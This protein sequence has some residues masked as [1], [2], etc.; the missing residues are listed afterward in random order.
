MLSVLL[1][2]DSTAW[3]RLLAGAVLLALALN[4]LYVIKPKLKERNRF[5]DPT[6]LRAIGPNG[7]P[8]KAGFL[9][10]SSDF[11]AGP[12][13][14]Y[15]TRRPAWYPGFGSSLPTV[16]VV[17]VPQDEPRVRGWLNN[18]LPGPDFL[19]VLQKC[20]PDDWPIRYLVFL[21]KGD[22]TNNELFRGR[23]VNCLGK[24]KE[25]ILPRQGAPA[26][27]ILFD[28]SPLHL[29][30]A[31]RPALDPQVQEKQLAGTFAQWDIPGF[32]Q[33]LKDIT[34]RYRQL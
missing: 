15:F 17:G 2:K 11:K 22:Y 6:L 30:E 31:Q 33:R 9:F 1:R 16:S 32:D 14:S 20:V 12:H 3:G 24:K 27:L 28:I 7:L 21:G 8:Q 26:A 18:T 23:A 19:R 13:F 4:Q 34:D 29:Y 5:T 25:F 10:N